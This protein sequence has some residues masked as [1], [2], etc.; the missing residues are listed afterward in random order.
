MS[1]L[2]WKHRACPVCESTD[3]ESLHEQRFL[4]PE[5][6]PLADRYTVVCC[7]GCGFV[8]ADIV[9]DQAKFDAFYADCSKYEDAGT[10]TGG[11]FAAWDQQRLR[12]TAQEIAKWAPKDARVLDIGCANGG[13]LAEL[14]K[15]GFSRLTGIDPS[16]ACVRNTARLGLE[17]KK[18][19]FSDLAGLG[20][21]DLIIVSHVLEHVHDL[22]SALEAIR[23]ILAPAGLVYA[24]TPDA[25][26]YHQFI[27]APFQDFNTEHINHFSA[28]CLAR[29]FHNFGF[30]RAGG[31]AKNVQSSRDSLTPAVFGIFHRATSAAPRKD[32]DLRECILAYIEGSRKLLR[33]IDA[34]LDENLLGSP[35][36]IVWGT[37]QLTMKLLCESS[38]ARQNIAAFVDSNPINQGKSLRGVR[39]ISP[40]D[41]SESGLDHPIVI[42]SL[43]H[44]RDITDAIRAKYGLANRLIE[45]RPAEASPAR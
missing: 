30:A 43:L 6:H 38:L 23:R 8:Y 10:A 3:A 21:F 25:S 26:R 18:G 16:P 9:I 24:E 11:G 29:L 28:T 19:S 5:G 41:L 17:S 2:D 45:L 4:L 12:D 40:Q 1:V 39:V 13:L 22:R 7:R 32:D 42:G 27:V 36:V 31:G 20:R 33:Q 35:A 14:R 44:G 34:Q 37:G 15:L